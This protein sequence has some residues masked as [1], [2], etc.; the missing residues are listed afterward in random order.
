MMSVTADAKAM[1]KALQAEAQVKD[2]A[3]VVLAKIAPN[4]YGVIDIGANA[5]LVITPG[6]TQLKD[7]TEHFFVL[8]EV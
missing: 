1:A 6:Y 4:T 2:L 7:P 5:Y 8:N 3:D